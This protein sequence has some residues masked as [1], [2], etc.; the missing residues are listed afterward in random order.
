MRKKLRFITAV[1]VCVALLLSSVMSGF[2]E[3]YY[4][5]EGY[6]YRD[7]DSE[8]ICLSGWD[9]SSD[10]LVVPEKI[11][12]RY[13]VAIDRYAFKFDSVLK[14]I[15]LS[16]N[17]HLREIGTGAF[18]RCTELT[19]MVIPSWVTNLSEFMF[20]GCTSMISLD[21]QMNAAVIPDEMCNYCS[22][23]ARFDVPDSV[24]EIRRYAFANCTS[25]SY[26]RIPSGV[27]S[28][29]ASSFYNCPNLVIGVYY[30]SYAQ[31]YAIDHNINYTLLDGV[32][33]GDV[34]GKDGVKI[35]DV[36][37]IQSYLA[38]L[39][40]LE[41]VYLQAADANQDGIVDISDATAIQMYIA[42]YELPYP[43]GQYFTK[44]VV[45]QENN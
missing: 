23:L 30:G 42:E 39:I 33:L 3:T 15:D 5:Y 27:Q 44:E 17:S 8:S 36:T 40:T 43:I 31:Q 45:T 32:L 13:I 26:V 22:S 16:Q 4:I 29:A 11:G 2:A 35:N 34:D 25:L 14:T 20:L 6:K 12:D 41:G 7:I 1:I 21:V 9:D 38:E 19:S 37:M 18:A 28:I 10:T 24:T